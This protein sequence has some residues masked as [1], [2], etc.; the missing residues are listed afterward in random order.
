MQY[1]TY[2]AFQAQMKDFYERTGTMMQFPEMMRYMAAHGLL[3]PT[4]PPYAIPE[5]YEFLS[6]AEFDRVVDTLPLEHAD[7]Q[8][9][10]A[11]VS[12]EDIIPT[13]QDV[14]VIRHPRYTRT[15]LHAHN[16]FEMVCLVS[17]AM[18]FSFENEPDKVL[19]PGEVVIVAPGSR[20]D[21]YIRDDTSF[22][23]VLCIRKSTFQTA[24]FRQLEGNNLLSYF[25]QTILQ[26]DG[27][28][29]YLMFYL[30]NI[31][32]LGRCLRSAMIECAYGD[33]YSN[34]VVIHLCQLVFIELLRNYSQTISY[35]NYEM[36]SDFSLV[37]QY[38]QHNYRTLSLSGLA[39]FFH[40]SEPHLCTLIRKNTGHT[41]SDLIREL[42]LEDAKRYLRETDLR[43]AEIADR[44]GYHSADH[45]S[46]VFRAAMQESPQAY[47]ASQKGEG[48]F[49]PFQNEDAGTQ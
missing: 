10:K 23:F 19:H 41:F 2:G 24:F 34:A 9:L 31:T 49:V 4:P 29:N 38:I 15:F 6:D 5:G 40:Y 14:M 35:Y 3:S 28:P 17:G 33:A 45:F 8:A 25:F 46:R 16:Y 44:V 20:H 43:I 12:E 18:T 11:S 7:D 36:G 27:H 22:A 1:T 13:R 42:R 39:A 48:A 37:L 26:G 32:R 47:R 21:M 30:K